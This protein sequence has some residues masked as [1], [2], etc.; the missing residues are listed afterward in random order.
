M[1]HRHH[2][3]NFS[4]QVW[5]LQLWLQAVSLESLE[6]RLHPRRDSSS[7]VTSFWVEQFA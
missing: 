2:Q 4:L 7:L 1:S 6:H 5:K 3:I